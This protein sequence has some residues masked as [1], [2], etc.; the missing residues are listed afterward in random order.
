MESTIKIIDSQLEFDRLKL[1]DYESKDALKRWGNERKRLQ[2]HF[3]G[4]TRH[5]RQHSSGPAL[6]I[7]MTPRLQEPCA[8][9]SNH[10]QHSGAVHNSQCGFGAPMLQVCPWDG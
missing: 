6:A 7:V 1:V 2:S 4:G 8:G 10:S 3:R 9:V 5:A